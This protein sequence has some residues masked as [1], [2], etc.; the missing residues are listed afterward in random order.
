[1]SI[2]LEAASG[3]RD[4]DIL[5]AEAEEEKEVVGLHLVKW[6]IWNTSNSLR[7]YTLRTESAEKGAC[8]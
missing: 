6:A 2:P 5:E 3:G 4:G 8:S 1:M 7:W